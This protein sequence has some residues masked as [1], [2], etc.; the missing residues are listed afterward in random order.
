MRSTR[1]VRARAAAVVGAGLVVIGLAFAGAGASWASSHG[2]SWDIIVR[3]TPARE[4]AVER[5]TVRL[6][7]QIRQRLHLING[8]TATLPSSAVTQLRS[9]RG[10][11]SVSRD[12]LLKAMTASYDPASDPNS[13]DQT[14]TYTGAQYWWQLG[15]TGQGIDIAL[16]DSGVS[17]VPGLDDPAKLIYGPDLSLESQADNLTNLDTYGHGTFMAGII[18]GR[19]SGLDPTNY[20]GAPATAYRG[21]APDA[22]I[23]SLKVATADGGT[24]VSQVIA[25]VDWVVQHA[26]DPGLNIRVINLSY[27]TNSTQAYGADPLSF[28]VEQAWKKGIVVVAAAGNTGYQRG[29]GAPGLADPAYNPF[30]IAVGASDSN[31]TLIQGD[32][33]VAP[34]SA[35]S[36][37]CSGCRNPDVVAPGSHVQGLR[38]ENS[39]LDANH[40]EAAFDGRYFRGSGSSE[41]AAAVSGGVA[42][43]LQRYPTLSPDQVKRY[44][45]Q[46]AVPLAGVDATQQGAGM[47]R[48][49][50]MMVKKPSNFTQ[51]FTAAT[52]T[53]SLEAARGSDHLTDDG[54]VLTGE[55]DIFG[56][57][58]NSTQMAKLEKTGTSWSGGTWN[59]NRWS[60]DGW[61]GNRWSGATWTGNSWSG[62]SWLGNRWSGN[63]WSGNRW[64]GNRW[65]GNSWSGNSWSGKAWTEYWG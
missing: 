16:I 23:V 30:V 42:L 20:A 26:H 63:T 29:T 22:R 45:V 11:I 46:Y 62:Q 24:D 65:S 12:R 18:A 35:S 41:A 27:G 44:F 33:Y 21:M 4:P 14:T 37:G 43:V 48:M 60:G 13:M 17:P 19:D 1:S 6:G 53:G 3:A 38:A 59:G 49:D 36:A 2:S 54:V 32:D 64:S 57:A 8:F 47:I 34:F 15:F 55:K 51:R 61:L 56:A 10:V 39:Y 28:A 7:G 58:F 5:A 31:G 40:P 25:A 9:V 52:G 50:K